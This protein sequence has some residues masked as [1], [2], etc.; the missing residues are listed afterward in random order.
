[1]AY[2]TVTGM[3]TAQGE[4]GSDTTTAAMIFA[5]WRFLS[6]LT[7]FAR[8]TQGRIHYGTSGPRS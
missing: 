6:W 3:T 8:A 1:M 4:A 5:K 7:I 2:E